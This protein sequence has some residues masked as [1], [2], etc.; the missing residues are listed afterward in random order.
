MH[1]R[2]TS[3]DGLSLVE[4]IVAMAVFLISLIGLTE[5]LSAGG[6]MATDSQRRSQ[7]ARLCLSKL[8]EKQAGVPVEDQGEFEEAPGFSWS[9][10]TQAG[11]TDL[12]ANVIVTVSFQ[13][14]DNTA[15]SVSL[16]QM[17]ID[18]ESAGS[19]YDSYVPSD[20]TTT[21]GSTSGSTSSS[22][23]TSS[24]SGAASSGATGAA[25]GAASGGGTAASSGAKSTGTTA[26]PAATGG[27]GMT[28]STGMG[29]TGMGSTGGRTGGAGGKN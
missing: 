22:S 20:G 10:E 6:R 12:L 14:R 21:P 28:G 11:A 18:P 8:A 29:S 9:I 15:V 27:T 16:S 26:T 13:R 4:V 7:A 19:V 24:S 1:L 2:R 3:R 17:I 5:L 23:T 25:S